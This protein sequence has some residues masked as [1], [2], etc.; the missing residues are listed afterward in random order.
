MSILTQKY[1]ATTP[2]KK[3]AIFS[4]LLGLFVFLFLLVFQPFG[5]STSENILGESAGFGLTCTFI[6]FVLNIMVIPLFPRFF[7]EDNWLVWKEIVWQLINVGLVGLGNAYYSSFVF[8]FPFTPKLIGIFEFYTV[9]VAAVPISVMT[10]INFKV[11]H[12]RYTKYSDDLSNR[13]KNHEQELAEKKIKI[14]ANS[15]ML[16][17]TPSQLLFI[18]AS[19][20]YI[21]V[22]YLD[23]GKVKREVLRKT[24]SQTNED[25]V[26]HYQIM[27]VHR[28]FIAN[29]DR[30]AHVS[31]NAQGLKLH[32]EKIDFVVPVSRNLTEKLRLRFADHH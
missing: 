20:N 2:A 30:V 29:L 9:A 13:V 18:K 11:K 10:L 32:F 5:L 28:S 6:V 17:L 19:D 7:D 3:R 23:Q 21:E 31:G 25:L 22:N 1:P 24:L 26:D 8:D 27:K 4:V 12:D 14:E 16:E 15:E